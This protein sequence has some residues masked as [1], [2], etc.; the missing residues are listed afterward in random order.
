M[1]LLTI[2]GHHIFKINGIALPLR[3]LKDCGIGVIYA[4]SPQAKGKIERSYSWLQA[5]VVRQCAKDN[6]TTFN[7]MQ[8]IFRNE[9]E[10]YN[11]R[12]VHSAT[13]EIPVIRFENA[14]QNG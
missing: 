12:Q 6:I 10:R 14:I 3:I 13:K 8:Q 2:S 1:I 11:T 5:R 7:N 4:L 9:I